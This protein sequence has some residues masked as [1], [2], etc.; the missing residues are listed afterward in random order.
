MGDIPDKH[1]GVCVDT[2]LDE[3]GDG[4]LDE[5]DFELTQKIKKFREYQ[6]AGKTKILLKHMEDEKEE[7]RKIHRKYE[8]YID[9]VV[10]G[11]KDKDH[12]LIR[13]VLL[14]SWKTYVKNFRGYYN[15]GESRYVRRT[16]KWLNETVIPNVNTEIK[17]RND[18]IFQARR[19]KFL[20]AIIVILLVVF[21]FVI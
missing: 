15:S 4:V 10:R 11:A 2:L 9:K 7:I 1:V 12:A 17:K 20:I 5:G 19:N 6:S 13:K 18:K 3:N 14:K 8:E 21:P 16:T